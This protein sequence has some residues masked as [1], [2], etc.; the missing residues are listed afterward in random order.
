MQDGIAEGDQAAEADAAEKDRGVAEF[1]DQQTKGRDLVVLGDEEPGLVGR[2]LAEQIER[3]D[4]KLPRHQ[5]FAIGRPQLGVLGEPVDQ[6]IDRC[7]RRPLDLIAESMWAVTEKWH[8]E[9]PGRWE[10]NSQSLA[11]E[12]GI[13]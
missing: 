2:A 10:G 1:V 13:P 6:D 11:R 12:T 4:T 9:G 7:V 3:R 5:G 8:R